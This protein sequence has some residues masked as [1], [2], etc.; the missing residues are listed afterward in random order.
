[1]VKIRG[2]GCIHWSK[3]KYN[4]IDA[5]YNFIQLFDLLIGYMIYRRLSKVNSNNFG[6]ANNI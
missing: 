4:I 6:N 5:I 2:I 1:M 3:K